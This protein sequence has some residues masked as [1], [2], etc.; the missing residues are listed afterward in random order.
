MSVLGSVFDPG[1]Q[2]NV[3][4]SYGTLVRD[5]A[6]GKMIVDVNTTGK[7]VYGQPVG[8]TG[9]VGSVVFG[10]LPGWAPMALVIGL[11]VVALLALHSRK[12]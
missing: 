2:V 8:G 1:V 10:N 3:N 7:P 9:T 6:T 5:P 11:F 12:T 4:G